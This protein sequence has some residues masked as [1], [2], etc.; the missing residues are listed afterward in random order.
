MKPQ[1]LSFAEIAKNVGER[2]KALDPE[3]RSRY[4]DAATSAKE[5]YNREL[6]AYKQT[7]QYAAHQRYLI[8]FKSSTKNDPSGK[9]NYNSTPLL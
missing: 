3:V 6:L 4:D 2:W 8:E 9:L 7:D 5:E 1:N